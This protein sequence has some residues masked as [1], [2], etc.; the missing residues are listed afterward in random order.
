MR[1]VVSLY[2]TVMF[3]HQHYVSTTVDENNISNRILLL[4]GRYT[5]ARR[6]KIVAANMAS[7]HSHKKDTV[8]IDFKQLQC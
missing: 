8:G 6:D 2:P 7:L 4:V 1:C 3:D 5:A